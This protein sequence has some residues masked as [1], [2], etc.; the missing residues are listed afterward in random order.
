[1]SVMLRGQGTAT[2]R[3]ECA[4]ASDGGP[5]DDLDAVPV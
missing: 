3:V 1:V 4:A 2:P 5:L